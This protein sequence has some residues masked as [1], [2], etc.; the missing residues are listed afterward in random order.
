MNDRDFVARSQQKHQAHPMP[1]ALAE[2]RIT[3][4]EDGHGDRETAW[5]SPY[6]Q[7]LA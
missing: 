5:F 4:I 2:H 1:V 7:R 6:F 3:A